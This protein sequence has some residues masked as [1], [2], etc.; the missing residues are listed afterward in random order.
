MVIFVLFNSFL[1]KVESHWKKKKHVTVILLITVW[2]WEN[3]WIDT[4]V[5]LYNIARTPT[6]NNNRNIIIISYFSLPFVFFKPSSEKY[7]VAQT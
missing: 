7:C 4:D 1:V 3:D 2:E 5:Q 6:L